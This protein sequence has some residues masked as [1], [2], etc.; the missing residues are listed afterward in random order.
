MATYVLGA[1]CSF[2]WKAGTVYLP[3]LLCPRMVW[4]PH[5][6]EI[7]RWSSDL[8]VPKDLLAH[9]YEIKVRNLKIRSKF[10]YSCI[11][12]C[13]PP[14]LFIFLIHLQIISFS[15][16]LTPLR[17]NSKIIKW[18][19]QINSEKLVVTL[20]TMLVWSGYYRGSFVQSGTGFCL[21]VSRPFCKNIPKLYVG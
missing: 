5:V 9:K 8:W 1:P 7:M 19:K 11:Q 18:K 4:L 16:K 21:R 12:Y 10:L 13:I 3:V 14:L 20:K 17:I 6:V 15:L 2:T